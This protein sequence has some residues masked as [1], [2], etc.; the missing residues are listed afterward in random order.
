MGVGHLRRRRRVPGLHRLGAAPYPGKRKIMGWMTACVGAALVLTLSS[1][2]QADSAAARLAPMAGVPALLLVE[3]SGSR[4]DW[5]NWVGILGGAAFLGIPPL[6]GFASLWV[7][8]DSLAGRFAGGSSVIFLLSIPLVV[9]A[10][11]VCGTVSF[12]SPGDA[13]DGIPAWLVTGFG[14]SLAVFLLVVG[15]YP[16]RLVDLLMR[17]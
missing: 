13:E 8:V 17:E 9:L 10:F 15:I 6:A 16:G 3:A 7:I 4:E 14:L 2:G 11:L 1:V 12:L 5:G